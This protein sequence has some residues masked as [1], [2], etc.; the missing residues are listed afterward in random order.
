VAPLAVLG[1][2][3]TSLT[4]GLSVGAAATQAR[5]VARVSSVTRTLT[6]SGIHAMPVHGTH[7][8]PA[9]YATVSEAGLLRSLSPRPKANATFKVAALQPPVVSST[10]VNGSTPGLLHSREGI[11]LLSQAKATGF[12]FVPP[13]QALCAGNGYVVEAVNTAIRVFKTSLAGASKTADL[14][15]F[16]GYPPNFNPTTKR[17]GPE[18][19]DPTCLFDHAT[20]RFFVVVLTLDTDPKT[21]DLTLV[22]HLD[23]AVSRTGNALGRYNIYKIPVTD[24]GTQGTP[25]HKGCPCVGDYPHIGLD[26]Y[27]FYVTTNEYPFSDAPGVYGNNFNGAQIYAMS[28]ARLVAG[29]RQLPLV[30]FENTFLPSGSRKVPGFSVWPAQNP[31]SAFATG[32]G[33]TQYFTSSIAADEARPHA[34]TGFAQRIGQWAITNTRSLATW[35]PRL[36]LSRALLSSEVYG[37]PPASQQKLGP[38]PLRDCVIINCSGDGRS[39]GE[40]EGPLDSLDSRIL[41]TWYAQGRLYTAL[42]TV[43]RVNG[44][45]QAGV[46]WFEVDPASSPASASVTRQGYVGSTNQNVIFP[47]IATLSNGHGVMAV[48]IAGRSYFPTAAYLPFST[49]NGPGGI[50]IYGLGRSPN[51]DFCEYNVFN[52]AGTDTP[53]ARPRFGDYSAAVQDG[54]RIYTGNQYVQSRCTFREFIQ[55]STCGGTRTTYGN[56]STRLGVFAP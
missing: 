15:P 2:V 37:V 5:P 11:N 43:M 45:L 36:N 29:A 55:D 40:D 39:P 28:K 7:A 18:L 16:F 4:V 8:S 26:R 22:N 48:T 38:V 23:I 41:T 19:T 9:G 56:W 14:N 24:D 32:H 52:C 34:P 47:S 53:L 30:Q 49:A 21:G 12:A 42:D 46:A 25:H 54:A 3:G 31:D 50:S 10:P 51:D 1:L 33:G 44:N 27:G 13:D 6:R 35:H 17:W 20:G